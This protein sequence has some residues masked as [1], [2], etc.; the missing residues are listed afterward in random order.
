MAMSPDGCVASDNPSR[1][2]AGKLI[3]YD[4]G[5]FNQDGSGTWAI[6]LEGNNMQRLYPASPRGGSIP[7]R[8]TY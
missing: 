8:L 2:S 1:S 7:L 5:S 4:R 6:D 3:I